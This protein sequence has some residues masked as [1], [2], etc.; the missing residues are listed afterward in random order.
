MT[1]LSRDAIL[2]LDDTQYEEVQVP[3]WG[4]MVRVKGL[5]GNQRAQIESLFLEEAPGLGNRQDRRNGS[6]KA[7]EQYQNRKKAAYA[8]LRAKVC[9]WSIV[10]EQ[11]NLLFTAD[12]IAAINEKQAGVIERIF[13]VARRLSG[14]TEKDV[15]DTAE[16]MLNGD[17]FEG[18]SSV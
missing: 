11:G 17:P 15:E 9:T 12:D 7:F 2:T 16:A 4:G 18:S 8:I 5:S 6:E 13:D 1:Y 10:D 3:E 14:L